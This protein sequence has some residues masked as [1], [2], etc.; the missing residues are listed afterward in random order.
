M[1]ISSILLAV[2]VLLAA[3]AISILLFERLLFLPVIRVSPAVF[4]KT[5]S[6]ANPVWR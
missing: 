1:D 2:V 4:G 3:T 6:P 5:T